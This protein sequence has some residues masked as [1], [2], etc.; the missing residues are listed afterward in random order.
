MVSPIISTLPLMFKDPDHQTLPKTIR[1]QHLLTFMVYFQD[2]IGGIP[3]SHERGK[4]WTQELTK[5]VGT[6]GRSE[7]RRTEEPSYHLL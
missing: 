2:R 4:T 1:L 3:H 5:V 6:N 7:L